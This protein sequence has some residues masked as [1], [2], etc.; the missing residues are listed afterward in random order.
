MKNI[1]LTQTYTCYE[2]K[3]VTAL[4]EFHLLGWFNFHSVLIRVSHTFG[5]LHT[6]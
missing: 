6:L 4:N 3:S 5:S 2:S 1:R